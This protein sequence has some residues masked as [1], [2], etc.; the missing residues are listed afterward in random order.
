M[1][2]KNNTPVYSSTEA[3][4]K[5]CVDGNCTV[6]KNESI[7]T[8]RSNYEIW[9]EKEK[10]AAKIQ[11]EEDRKNGVSSTL[12]PDCV[13]G[14]DYDYLDVD[15][16][17][18]D[19]NVIYFTKYVN[20]VLIP[21]EREEMRQ[22]KETGKAFK[23]CMNIENLDDFTTCQDYQQ[24]LL[25]RARKDKCLENTDDE[26]LDCT[27]EEIAE[28][29]A[30]VNERIRIARIKAREQEEMAAE[31]ARLDR[32]EK[33]GF[34][35]IDNPNNLTLYGI[36]EDE[37]S[38]E[39]ADPDELTEE[40]Y[41]EY[42]RLINMRRRKMAEANPEARYDFVVFP[43]K[44]KPPYDGP[45]TI[46]Y[47]SLVETLPLNVS[48][49]KSI[50]LDLTPNNDT[51]FNSTDNDNNS[52]SSEEIRTEDEIREIL[53]R[54]KVTKILIPFEQETSF[55]DFIRG[56]LSNKNCLLTLGLFSF[57]FLLLTLIVTS[58]TCLC[59]RIQR[60]LRYN[61]YDKR[62]H[63]IYRETTINKNNSNK[64]LV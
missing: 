39:R 34:F 48:V 52:T 20:T 15:P 19:I 36:F 21:A 5:I 41:R 56:C 49:T 44:V 31:M 22:L 38:L 46:H 6:P 9:L 24:K 40:E 14:N 61:K 43:D 29:R 45:R 27:P 17:N 42:V 55:L 64:T 60:N 26:D 35:E 2:D 12:P 4:E 11:E 23:E 8:S 18:P 50:F 16:C 53:N 57:G 63:R 47:A 51:I 28:H 33:E 54:T 59:I 58:I 30:F 13:P 10:A 62:S 37:T 32:L 3:P 1:R 7:P 25:D